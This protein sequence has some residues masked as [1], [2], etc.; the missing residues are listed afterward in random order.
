MPLP[1]IVRQQRELYQVP[2]EVSSGAPMSCFAYGY[3][4]KTPKATLA[5]PSDTKPI[6]S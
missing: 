5:A 2:V 4:S 3:C 6:R 1:L